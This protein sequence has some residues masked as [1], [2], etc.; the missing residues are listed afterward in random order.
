MVSGEAADFIRIPNLSPAYDTEW[1]TN[2]NQEAAAKHILDW[3]LAQGVDG[4]KGE[5]VAIKGLT[6]VVF[7]EI[8]AT[9]GNTRNMLMYGHFDKQPPMTG[10]NE[11]LAPCK[12][13]LDGDKLYGRGGAD[14][15]Y[16]IYGSIMSVLTCQK[17]KIPHGRCVILIEGSEESGSIHLPQYVDEL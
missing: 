10:W 12:P 15:G 6:P 13:V 14:D 9:P 4:L 11:G 8:D 5:I 7:L 2:G 1:Q 17:Y 3:A 16:A